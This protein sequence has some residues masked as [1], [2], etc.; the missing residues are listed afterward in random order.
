M[1]LLFI[2]IF[3][4]GY[5]IANGVVEEKSSRVVEVVLSA[6]RPSHL[7]AGKVVG[8]GLLGLGQ[9]TLLAAI[10][11]LGSLVL[12]VELPATAFAASGAVLLWF[13]LGYAFYGCL[14]AI[15][16]SLVSKQEDLQYSQLPIMVVILAGY[17][18]AF[19]QISN[20]DS[21]VARALA[22]VPPFT[23]MIMLVRIGLGEV[24]IVEVMIA[25]LVMVAATAGLVSLA[26]R[27]YAG[28]VLR[29][30]ART[31]LRDAWSSLRSGPKARR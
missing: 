19:F 25:V 3:T 17:G 15:A 11:Y 16:G 18:A 4:Y 6:I 7:L 29:F 1:L 30:G 28:S 27:L 24:G 13:V 22:F 31:G 9:L 5:W 26:A 14:F 2:T 12:A 20:P 21:L 8:I 10:G 23:P